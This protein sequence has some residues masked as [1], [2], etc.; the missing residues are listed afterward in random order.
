[1]S[2]AKIRFR[3]TGD[4][5]YYWIVDNV[6]VFGL[7][8]SPTDLALTKTGA[9]TVVCALGTMSAAQSQV[10]TIAVTA[11]DLGARLVNQAT[12][13]TA[14]PE[15]DLTN[16]VASYR[17]TVIKTAQPGNRYV[18][19]SGSDTTDCTNPST[20]CR[21]VDFAGLNAHP[22]DVIHVA[23]G[24]YTEPVQID[25]A[26]IIQGAGSAQTNL[27]GEDVRQVLNASA[28][29]HLMDLSVV[30]GRTEEKGG[31]LFTTQPLTLTN[32]R[33]AY[34]YSGDQGGGFFAVQ[35]VALSNTQVISNVSVD[36]GGGAYILGPLNMAGSLVEQNRCI[37][38]IVD[39]FVVRPC[40]GGGLFVYN[41]VDIVDSQF[42]GNRSLLHGGG[43]VLGQT[44]QHTVTLRN[45]E[46]VGNQAGY[47]A[48]GAFFH[49]NLVGDNVRFVQNKAGV[50]GGGMWANS[51]V[52]LTHSRFS[53]NES[54]SLGGGSYFNSNWETGRV[55]LT[56]VLYEGNHSHDSGGGFFVES[57][58]S[59]NLTRTQFIEN[60][61]DKQG[62]GFSAN[63]DIPFTITD[64]LIQDNQALNGNGG[65]FSAG[66]GN[67]F[68]I[69]DSRI[70]G[71]RSLY[72]SGGGGE[73]WGDAQLTAVSVFSNTS[74]QYD[75]GGIFFAGPTLTILFLMH[76]AAVL[77]GQIMT[78][79]G[80]QTFS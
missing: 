71:N 19:T 74:T 13:S 33:F 9:L 39:I 63:S 8:Q 78:V 20:P 34:N 52:D 22:G 69:T 66:P 70:Q 53:Q 80:I 55:G 17:T 54:G 42:V 28:P 26:L 49:G 64:S 10:I 29:V 46:F 7:D 41:N 40:F 65:G 57:S 61:A 36:R 23:A 43:A 79:M 11:P 12:A 75:G 6:R 76:E 2:N 27:S 32:V 1:M 73:L 15:I 44:D 37:G 48:G 3:Y 4:F 25:R 35:S 45:V 5:S 56:D 68:S 14:T 62:G 21:T 47:N 18:S 51:R 58:L 24:L 50:C 31:G 38:V 72:G 59:V 67:P 77:V 60:I 30:N 16:N